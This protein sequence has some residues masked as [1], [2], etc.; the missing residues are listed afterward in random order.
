MIVLDMH[1]SLKLSKLYVLEITLFYLPKKKYM[2]RW[3]NN[4]PRGTWLVSDKNE[5]KPRLSDSM[6]GSHNNFFAF[7]IGYLQQI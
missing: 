5:L 6:A 1:I 4:I 7:L 2:Q 3:I